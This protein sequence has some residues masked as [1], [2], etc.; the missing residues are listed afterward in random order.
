MASSNVGGSDRNMYQA[1][2]TYYVRPKQAK[3]EPKLVTS[4]LVL[5]IILLSRYAWS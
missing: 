1:N 4:S 2:L 5:L 3:Q